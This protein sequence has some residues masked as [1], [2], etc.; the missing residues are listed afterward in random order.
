M[1]MQSARQPGHQPGRQVSEVVQRIVGRPSSLTQLL[2][3]GEPARRISEST[4]STSVHQE[5]AQTFPSVYSAPGPSRISTPGPSRSLSSYPS[6]G[7]PYR[8]RVYIPRPPKNFLKRVVLVG[9]NFENV[10]KGKVRQQ[11]HDDGCI[12]DMMEFTGTWDEEAVMK[13]LMDTFNPVL[14]QNAPVPRYS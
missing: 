12:C 7:A 6:R 1:Q 5:M 11:L 8:Q 14:D 13:C 9:P 2:N 10:P 4:T 3:R